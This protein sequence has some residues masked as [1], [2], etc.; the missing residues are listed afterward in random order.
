MAHGFAR[1]G[2]DPAE[3]LDAVGLEEASLEGFV[4]DIRFARALRRVA[5]LNR[6]EH[7]GIELARNLPLGLFGNTDYRFSTSATFADA[8]INAGGQLNDFLGAAIRVELHL[9]E[10]TARIRIRHLTQRAEILTELSILTELLTAIQVRRFRDVLGDA[11]AELTGVQF[12]HP[13]P[14]SIEVHE[15]F[16]RAPVAF[17]APVD[18]VS[19]PRVLLDVPL[20]TADPFLADALAERQP[21]AASNDVE[22]DPFLDRLRATIAGSLERGQ[23]AL[24]VDVIAVGLQTSGRSLQRKL[25]ERRLS[26]SGLIDE[27]RRVRAAEL[28]SQEGILLCDVAYQLGF[29]SVG[30]FFRA[31]RRWTGTSPRAFQ[32]R[33]STP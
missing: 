9:D 21:P 7:P 29:S 24:G 6:I 11:T 19:F 23:A 18:E 28:L 27:V 17:N 20:Q 12:L 30:P 2:V 3:F 22:S 16:F 15:E 26:L 14:P 1:L 10:H 4:P 33:G 13:A 25:R 31:F 5:S 8:L 32:G